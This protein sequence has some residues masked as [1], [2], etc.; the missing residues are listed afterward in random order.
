MQIHVTVLDPGLVAETIPVLTIARLGTHVA[1]IVVERRPDEFAE[2][3]GNY[4]HQESGD[5]DHAGKPRHGQPGRPHNDNFTVGC[6]CP[7]PQQGADQC[8]HGQHLECQ[9]RQTQRC[10]QDSLWRLVI[11]LHVLEFR[12]ELEQSCQREQHDEDQRRAGE[13]RPRQVLAQYAVHRNTRRCRL[14]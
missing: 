14:F 11:A 6:Q 7:E 10:K 2:Q 13:D 4:Q 3:A 1:R 12:D 5:R 8:G 9:I